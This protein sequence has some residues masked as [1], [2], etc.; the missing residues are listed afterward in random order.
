MKALLSIFSFCLLLAA[1]NKSKD[2]NPAPPY[3]DCLSLKEGLNNNNNEQVAIEIN[4]LCTDLL[5]A[6]TTGDEYGQKGN[7]RILAE[8]LSKQCDLTATVLCYACVETLPPQS[9][10]SISFSRNGNNYTYIIDM[11]FTRQNMLRFNS[12]HD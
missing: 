4:N 11:T 10:L 8:R 7:L 5:P 3:I 12:V 1:C 9:E 2:H 6:I